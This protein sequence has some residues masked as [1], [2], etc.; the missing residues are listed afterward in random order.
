ML[1]FTPTLGQV[2]V[3]TPVLSCEK[4][5]KEQILVHAWNQTPPDLALSIRVTGP[6]EERWTQAFAQE[7]L[8]LRSEAEL[9]EK[10]LRYKLA[11]RGKLHLEWSW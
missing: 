9:E 10:V 7:D 11:V 6:L 1:G 4:D 2:R 8:I 3:A 5:E